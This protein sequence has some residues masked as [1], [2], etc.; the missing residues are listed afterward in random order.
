M[1]PILYDYN[2]TEFKSNGLGLLKDCTSCFVEEERNETYEIELTYPV[3]SF[4]YDKLKGNRYIK[5]KSNNRYEPQIFRIYYVS[6]PINGEITVKAEH[7]SYKLNDNFV[8][9]ATCN[10]NCQ[11]ALNTLNSNAAFPTGFKFYSNISMNTNF[12]VEL[13]NLW[14]C[15]KGTEGSI[16]DTYGNGTD[17]VRDNFKVSVVQNGGQDNNVLICYKKNMT[18]FTCEENWT[19]CI[20]RIYPYVEKDNVRFV[21]PEKYIDSSYINRDPNPRIAKVDFSNY[22]QDDEEFNIEKL[23]I[24]AKT[25]FKENNCDI[26]SLNYNVEFVLLSQTEEFKNILKDEN[27]ELFDKVIIRHDL[28]GID[29][30][31]KILKVKYNNLLEKYENIELNFTKNTIT[32]TI[33]NT[34]KKIEETKEELNKKNNNLKV[35]MEKRDSEIELS[36]KNEKEDREASIKVLDGKIEEK[37]S[38]EDFGSYR[39]QTAKVIREKVSEGDFSTLVE[40]NAQSVLIAIKNETEMN[41]IFDS[42]GQ[43]IKNGALVVKDS[44]GKTVMRFNKDGTVGVQDIEV[45]NRDKYSALYRTLSNMDELWFRDVGIDHL[46]IENDAFYIKD[47]DFGKGY[48]LKHFIRMVLKDEGL[49]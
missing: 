43:T 41:V 24:L 6:Q 47:D 17:I 39:E 8:E 48:N 46:V 49:I 10:G 34:N 1:I 25:Y 16:V 26:P 33:N 31:V 44:K 21:L 22:F 37:V 45:I 11:T 12:N 20:T 40:K 19:G 9:K 28:Y 5:A 23:R 14:D 38:E 2:E 36:V 29:I 7:I 27:I 13:V 3:G 35:T 4:L 42:D 18:G 30:K 32:S 15:I